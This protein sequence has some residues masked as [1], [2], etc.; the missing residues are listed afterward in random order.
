[1]IYPPHCLGCGDFGLWLCRSCENRALNPGFDETR[2][3]LGNYA[4]PALRT[5]IGD[6]KY[7]SA[8]CLESSISDLLGS[9]RQKLEPWIQATHPVWIMPVPGDERRVRERGIDH[10]SNI[11]RLVQAAYFPEAR[12]SSALVRTKQVFANAQLPHEA[13]QANLSRAFA[14][15]QPL[16]GEVLL[17]DDVFT[18]GATTRACS[19]ALVGSGAGNVRIFTLATASE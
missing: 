8:S 14:C 7:H 17:I 15:I 10:A 19:E 18:S 16:D 3:W 5:L 1:M 9:A 12:L 4:E 6:L 2:A 13:R 11:A